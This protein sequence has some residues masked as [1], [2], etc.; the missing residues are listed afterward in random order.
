ML[1][2]N[3]GR[4]AADIPPQFR[5]F[6]KGE[7]AAFK[8]F[9]DLYHRPLYVFVLNLLHSEA[10][11]EEITDD[12][13][14][15]LWDDR[16]KINDPRH[17]VNF[18]YIVA[19]RQAFAHLMKLKRQS[20]SEEAW[21]KYQYEWATQLDEVEMARDKILALIF[22]H[23]DKLPPKQKEVFLLNFTQRMDVRSIAEKLG[24]S[25]KNVYKHLTKTYQY[26]KKKLQ[27]G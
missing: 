1:N 23:I 10:T 14:V 13:F 20:E 6:K 21:A 5:L 3:P 25:E 12:V 18:L 4:S 8:F 24:T 17:L 9:Y 7:G 15:I 11:A 16:D 19:R 22:Q 27:T 2:N 26:L